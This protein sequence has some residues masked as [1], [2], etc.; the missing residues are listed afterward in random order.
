[1]KKGIFSVLFVAV[2]ALTM[3][4]APGV[5]ADNDTKVVTLYAGQHIDV[6][7]VSVWKDGDNLYVKYELAPGVVAEGWCIVETH[8]HVGK[9]PTDF[10]LAGRSGNPVPGR[11]DYKADHEPCVTECEYVIPLGDWEAGDVLLIA[12]QAV[13]ENET[14]HETAWADG[15][16]FVDRGNWATY[17]TYTVKEPPVF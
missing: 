12:A 6:G 16:R 17:F 1:V 8:V 15:T 13:V 5:M 2:L 7:T 9:E 11:F 10:P 3:G 4:L 14:D